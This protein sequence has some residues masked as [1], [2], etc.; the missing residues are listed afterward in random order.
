[1]VNHQRNKNT[2]KEENFIINSVSVKIWELVAK[3]LQILT[4]NL[5]SLITPFNCY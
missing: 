5:Y 2:E 4:S 3:R 1:M